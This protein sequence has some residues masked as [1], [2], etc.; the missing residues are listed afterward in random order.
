MIF[1]FILALLV[2]V[3]WLWPVAPDTFR[4]A[5]DEKSRQTRVYPSLLMIDDN[6]DAAIPV[7]HAKHLT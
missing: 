4:D 7:S 6:A 5:F 3:F 1:F 2:H